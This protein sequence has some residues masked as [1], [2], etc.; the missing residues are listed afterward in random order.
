M[1]RQIGMFLVLIGII[2][3]FIFAA[4]YQLNEPDYSYCLAG[5][6]VVALGAFLIYRN[7]RTPE[8]AERFRLMGRLRNRRKKD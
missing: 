1:G 8:P 5:V 3:A 4:S 6:I 7:R 2:V